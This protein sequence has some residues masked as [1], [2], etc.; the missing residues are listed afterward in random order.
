M[1]DEIMK[2]YIYLDRE[3]AKQGTS[4]VFKVSETKV[5][6]YKEYFEGNAVEFYGEDLPHFITYLKD[7]DSIRAA[8]EEEKLEKGDRILNDEEVV[9][10]GKI[11][12]YDSYSQK[13][14]EDQI[15]DKTRQDYINEGIISLDSEKEKARTKRE[16]EYAAYHKLVNNVF[17]GIEEALTEDE[18]ADIKVW[19][20]AW[21]DV[22]NNYKNINIGIE[23]S[24]PK[25]SERIN[26]YYN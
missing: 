25:R 9:I 6:N 16:K 20:K 11:V 21:K 18:S 14:V 10:D 1:E 2:N 19:H 7:S 3:K 13:I 8:T 23:D 17:M 12:S 22:P 4:L 24:Y 26:Y 5:D 15:V